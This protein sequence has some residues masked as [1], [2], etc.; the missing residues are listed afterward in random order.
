MTSFKYYVGASVDGFIADGS[1]D[2]HWFTTFAQQ[3]GVKKHFDQFFE[4]VGAV[5][6]GGKTYADIAREVAEG[7]MEWKFGDKPVWVF[8]HHELPT[9]PDTDLTFIRGEFGFWSRDIARSAGAGD[10]WIVGG[11]DVAG[12]FVEAKIL[13]EL[14]VVTV[15]VVLGEGTSIFGRGI[16]TQLSSLSVTD[17]GGDIFLSRYSVD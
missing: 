3:P 16:S 6:I 7:R 17:L 2:A 12:G 15:P 10:V 1:K 11:A 5:V 9:L 14:I 8:T 13:D 4:S